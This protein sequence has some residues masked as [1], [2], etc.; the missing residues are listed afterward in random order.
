MN[1]IALWRQQEMERLR[2]DMD[3]LFTRFRRSFGVPQPLFGGADTPV[4]RVSE[5]EKTVTASVDLPGIDPG[6]IEIDLTDDRLTLKGESK[7]KEVTEDESIRRTTERMTA[8]SQS[9]ALPC[10]IIPEE[11]RAS[12]KGGRLEI[13]LPKCERK[14]IRGIRIEVE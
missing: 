3:L 8:F 6:D 2:R 1:E 13:V 7:Q 4:V 9:I 5:G 11:V 14:M 10:R 12:F